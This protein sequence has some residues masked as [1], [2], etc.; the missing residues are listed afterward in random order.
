MRKVQGQAGKWGQYQQVQDQALA[1]LKHSSRKDQEKESE[2]KAPLGQCFFPN[3]IIPGYNCTIWEPLLRTA[4]VPQQ[5][6]ECADP[7]LFAQ[8]LAAPE[9]KESNDSDGVIYWTGG[10]QNDLAELKSE[11]RSPESLFCVWPRNSAM[12]LRHLIHIRKKK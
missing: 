6:A 7:I 12:T 5:G 9:E 8:V 10:S 11:S 1:Y 2:L 4:M 3:T